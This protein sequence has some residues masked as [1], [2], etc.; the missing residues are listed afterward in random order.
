VKTQQNEDNIPVLSKNVDGLIFW[1][2]ECEL[3]VRQV[4][5]WAKSIKSD[6]KWPRYGLDKCPHDKS[7]FLT[8]A[9]SA[10]GESFKRWRLVGGLLV[11]QGMPLKGIMMMKVV[12]F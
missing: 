1:L 7:I 5:F 4:D 6:N 8:M 9:L 12:F 3:N 11:I 2:E 10:G